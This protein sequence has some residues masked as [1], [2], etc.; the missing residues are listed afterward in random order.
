MSTG[1]DLIPGFR[2]FLLGAGTQKEQGSPLVCPQYLAQCLACVGIHLLS[3]SVCLGSW[4]HPCWVVSIL[5]A[6]NHKIFILFIFNESE[7]SYVV[8]LVLT[9]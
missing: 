4:V 2:T 8:L 1:L 6:S 7:S 9:V 5:G 3:K